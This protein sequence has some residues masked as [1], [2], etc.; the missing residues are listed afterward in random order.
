MSPLIQRKQL[1]IPALDVGDLKISVSCSFGPR[2]LALKQGWA[3]CL[4]SSEFNNLLFPKKGDRLPFARNQPLFSA[5]H[6]AS[7]DSRGSAACRRRTPGCRSQ[8]SNRNRPRTP[9]PRCPEAS[10]EPR[11]SK[12]KLHRWVWVKSK[13]PGKACFSHGFHLPGFH[14]GYP[15]LTHSQTNAADHV[16]C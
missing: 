1:F 11:A 2:L 8:S 16:G 15:F 7:P 14:F 3:N 6:G 13:P 5:F 9:A 4:S 10:H 12:L